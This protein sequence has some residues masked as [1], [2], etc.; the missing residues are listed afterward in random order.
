MNVTASRCGETSGSGLAGL[1][2]DLTTLMLPSQSRLARGETEREE[3]PESLAAFT[4]GDK[5]VSDGV[6]RLSESNEGLDLPLPRTESEGEASLEGRA[7][8]MRAL[9]RT[10]PLPGRGLGEAPMGNFT[11]DMLSQ[12]RD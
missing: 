10:R 9:A 5:M 8:G 6:R 11:V 2:I 12:S 1:P 4:R 7:S 3:A